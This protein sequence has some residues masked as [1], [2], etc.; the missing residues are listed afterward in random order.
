MSKHLPQRKF[1]NAFR[2]KALAAAVCASLWSFL[3]SCY[4]A[5]LGCFLVSHRANDAY[6][7]M[8]ENSFQ[9]IN[10]HTLNT[11]NGQSKSIIRFS[12]CNEASIGHYQSNSGHHRADLQLC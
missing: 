6:I 7:M 4:M 1:L 2:V 5:G 12:K 9:N 8:I 3:N 10:W 11:A